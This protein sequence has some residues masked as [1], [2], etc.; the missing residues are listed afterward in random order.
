VFVVYMY[1][2]LELFVSVPIPTLYSKFTKIS[3]MFH[4]RI[5]GNTSFCGHTR[6]I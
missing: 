1:R 4:I 2:F 5:V 6:E 3:Y